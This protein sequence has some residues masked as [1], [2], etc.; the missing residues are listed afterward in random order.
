M[1]VAVIGTI[2][3]ILVFPLLGAAVVLA[4]R[5][6]RV[7]RGT[8]LVRCPEGGDVVQTEVNPWRAALASAF[9]A[10]SNV[11]RACTHWPERGQCSQECLH[12]IETSPTGCREEDLVARWRDGRDC[13]VCGIHLDTTWQAPNQVAYLGPEGAT[14]QLRDLKAEDLVRLFW[15]CEP[16]CWDCH[17]SQ[18]SAAGLQ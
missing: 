8:R 16:V 13:A 1:D 7:S 5:G 9:G 14:S 11:V 4:V 15:S 10:E 2:V 18:A 3:A 6:Y 17:T 12:Q